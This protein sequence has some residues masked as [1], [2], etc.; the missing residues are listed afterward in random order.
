MLLKNIREPEGQL[1]KWLERL[2]EFDYEI[3]HGWDSH[4]KEILVSVLALATPDPKLLQ[5]QLD[6]ELIG[7]FLRDKEAN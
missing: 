5:S 7:P 2:Q 3:I 6:N 1:P 4:E